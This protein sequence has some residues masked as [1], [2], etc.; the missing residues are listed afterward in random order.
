MPARF[1]IGLGLLAGCPRAAPSPAPTG[2]AICPTA[3]LEVPASC[4]PAAGSAAQPLEWGVG[5][6]SDSQLWLGRLA[7]GD[8]AVPQMRR[9]RVS[10]APAPATVAPRSSVPL[11]ASGE[12]VMDVW[13]VQCPTDTEARQWIANAYR[14]GTLCPP[15][16]FQLLPADAA[17]ALA[18]ARDTMDP[19]APA[20]VRA[21]LNTAVAAAPGF[22]VT[23]F[24]QGATLLALNDPSG[25]LDSFTAAA[26]INPDNISGLYTRIILLRQAG[27]R[28]ATHELSFH[29]LAIT[30]PHH[31]QRPPAMCMAALAHSERGESVAAELLAGQACAQ[32]FQL[33][34]GLPVP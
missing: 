32:G 1:L 3:S 29:L 14:C 8:G 2:T 26:Q 21:H 17:V 12:E 16:G 27:E 20:T 23:H 11:P 34:C 30:P 28:D 6:A 24:T 4:V 33:C 10:E 19:P 18:A 5:A 13:A 31:P 25:A 22:E 15:E 9:L 7:C